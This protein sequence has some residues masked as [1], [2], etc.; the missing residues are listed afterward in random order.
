[1]S[2]FEK[3]DLVSPRPV[4]AFLTDFGLGDGDVGVLK[5]VVAGIAPT[6]QLLDFTHD[7]A[8]QNVASAAWILASGYRY[9]PKE[10]VFVC[11]VDPGVGSKRR[12][13]A[14]QAGSWYF[15]GPD[16]GLFTYILQEQILH[17][18]VSLENPAYRLPQVSTTF[19]GRDIFAPAG[20]YLARGI[21]IQELGPPLDPATL[22]RIERVAPVHTGSSID[23]IVVHVDNFGN[24]ITSISLSLLT[25]WPVLP[26][27]R[28]LF[29]QQNVEVRE[30]RRFFADGPLNDLPFLY[31]DSSGYLGVAIRNGNAARQLKIDLGAPVTFVMGTS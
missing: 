16:N 2:Q 4:I 29:P 26:A 10:T 27:A 15:V 24:L 5:G 11:V 9:F 18:V 7:I 3:K 30:I 23:A 6:A 17:N 13:I 21:A 31:G 28:L 1:M 12:A 25:A 14:L 19:H 20:A 22:Q 8:P